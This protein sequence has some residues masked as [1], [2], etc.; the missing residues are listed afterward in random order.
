M[1]VGMG[2]PQDAQTV[3]AFEKSLDGV[4]APEGVSL[5]RVHRYTSVA[6]GCRSA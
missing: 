3:A 2:D 1:N 6:R 4:T 5:S